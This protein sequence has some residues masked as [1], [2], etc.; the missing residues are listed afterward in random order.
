MTLTSTQLLARLGTAA[1][2]ALL[3]AAP[4]RPR[5]SRCN[6]T[7]PTSPT[8]RWRITNPYPSYGEG[9]IFFYKAETPDGCEWICCEHRGP[10]AD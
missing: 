7:S 6:S 9:D 1:A 3:L 5:T 10:G 8:T 4:R 2:L